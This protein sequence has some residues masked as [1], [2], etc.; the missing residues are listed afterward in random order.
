MLYTLHLYNVIFELYL[1]KLMG[2]TLG[3]PEKSQDY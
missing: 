1:N 3:S 2:R